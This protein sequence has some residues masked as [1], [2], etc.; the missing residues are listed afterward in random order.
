MKQRE[1]SI[2][3]NIKPNT[4]TT[5]GTAITST[6][7]PPSLPRLHQHPTGHSRTHPDTKP[8]PHAP[9][10]QRLVPPL[11]RR[12]HIGE[13][14]LQA[15]ALDKIQAQL[16]V[17]SALERALTWGPGYPEIKRVMLK[18]DFD[19]RRVIFG[20]E[21]RNQFKPYLWPEIEDQMDVLVEITSKIARQ[22]VRKMGQYTSS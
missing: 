16:N 4:T 6:S 18:C 5:Q 9:E 7:H 12:D 17:Q 3:L 11:P 15:Q 1:K 21:E 10:T 22:C 2:A 14:P 8:P 13:L 19:D 20:D